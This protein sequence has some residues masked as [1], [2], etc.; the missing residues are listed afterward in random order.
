VKGCELKSLCFVINNKGKDGLSFYPP[1]TERGH[2]VGETLGR[3]NG[4]ELINFYKGN[5][6]QR[7]LLS[8]MLTSL[9]EVDPINTQ[10]S[11]KQETQIG[12]I[13]GLCSVVHHYISLGIL[14]DEKNKGF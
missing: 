6:L 14:A 5:G 9:F 4:V 1:V 8:R 3:K 11:L 12:H 10:L 2:Q 7:E 13:K